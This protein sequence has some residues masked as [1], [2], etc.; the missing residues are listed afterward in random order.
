ML[1][2]VH[3]TTVIQTDKMEDQYWTAVNKAMSYHLRPIWSLVMI[4]LNIMLYETI[5]LIIVK[6]VLHT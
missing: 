4:I 1:L 2:F 3:F 6:P 5:A